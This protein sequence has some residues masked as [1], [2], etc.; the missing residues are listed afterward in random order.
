M[1]VVNAQD[2]QDWLSSHPQWVQDGDQI[3]C[4]L[5]FKNFVQAFGF[6][7]QIAILAEKHDH[8][9]AIHNVYNRVT[10]S[11]NTHDAGNKI[12]DRDLNLAQAIDDLRT[13][14]Q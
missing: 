3:R 7:S 12:T 14:S 4:N 5:T 2:L 8:H 9:P 13:Q 1:K 11:L 10:V 6:L